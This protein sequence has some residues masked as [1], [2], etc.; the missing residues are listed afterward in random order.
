MKRS[1]L[2]RLR[3]D[4]AKRVELLVDDLFAAVQEPQGHFH[5]SDGEYFV[6]S[7]DF[8]ERIRGRLKWGKEA[9]SRMEGFL[10]KH[11]ELRERHQAVGLCAATG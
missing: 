2:I 8:F 11:G 5:M 4:E 7:T 9:V 1:I 10:R 3:I 6:T